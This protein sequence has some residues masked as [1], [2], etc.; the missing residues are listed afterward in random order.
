MAGQDESTGRMGPPRPPTFEVVAPP[1][2]LAIEWRS[3]LLRAGRRQLL[4]LESEMDRHRSLDSRY[5]GAVIEATQ[6]EID[7][8][9][10]GIAWLWRQHS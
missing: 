1:D 8:L 10:Q 7:C 4:A 9:Q 2:P 6:M 5:A 3:C